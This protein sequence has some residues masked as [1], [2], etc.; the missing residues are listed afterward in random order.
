MRSPW[1]PLARADSFLEARYNPT[2]VRALTPKDI[3]MANQVPPRKPGPPNFKMLALDAR[4]PAAKAEVP[5]K[6]TLG[7]E[8][9]PVPTQRSSQYP[10]P[11]PPDLAQML[12][13]NA[14]A[15]AGIEQPSYLKDLPPS[16]LAADASELPDLPPLR[17]AGGADLSLAAT[18]IAPSAAR[19]VVSDAEALSATIAIDSLVQQK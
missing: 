7:Y 4:K 2:S 16:L 19:T 9:A 14:A 8:E 12:A 11:P 18:L 10:E 6:R 1:Q 17:V 13:A 3:P 5:L 15:P